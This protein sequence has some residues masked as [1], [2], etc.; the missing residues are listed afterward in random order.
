MNNLK[1]FTVH[2]NGKS[3]SVLAPSAHQAMELCTQAPF[4]YMGGT[5]SES[6]TN[7]W[8]GDGNS[9]ATVCMEQPC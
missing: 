2:L 1:R 4:L 6:S 9:A 3:H 8:V 5:P 7:W